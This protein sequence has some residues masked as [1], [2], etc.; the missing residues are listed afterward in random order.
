MVWTRVK[1]CKSLYDGEK[2]HGIP[3]L[4]NR[5]VGARSP[6]SK[7]QIER[8]R[9]IHVCHNKICQLYLKDNG[10]TQ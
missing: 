1:L 7:I 10:K 6:Q 8:G 3:R 4:E 2:W 5:F 9:Q